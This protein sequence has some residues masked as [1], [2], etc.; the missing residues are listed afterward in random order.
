MKKKYFISLV[1]IMICCLLVG[2]GNKDS[3]NKENSQNNQ[4]NTSKESNSTKE[5][6]KYHYVDG[7]LTEIVDEKGNPKQTDFIIDGIILIGNRHEYERKDN[8]TEI[9]DY[10]VKEG[11]KK[12]GINSS[13]YLGE[14][15]DFYID[16]KYSKSS[17]DVKIIVVPHKNIEELEKL[18]ESK[19]KELAE[20]NGGF[21][22]DY[23][24]PE[25]DNHK[26][27]GNGYVHQDYKEGKYDILFTYKGKIAYFIPINETKE[28][29][30]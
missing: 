26:Y 22:L 5:S 23:K 15:I 6:Y 30:E 1:L 2:C 18:S 29:E 13:F 3:N 21:V 28:I 7:K 24:T 12:E 16:T 9:I 17:N 11:Y 19:L 27:V 14:W 8:T 4:T 20:E 25:E 10:F